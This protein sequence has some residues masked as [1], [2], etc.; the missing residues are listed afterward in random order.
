MLA[1]FMPKPF[2]NLTGNGLHMHLSMWDDEDDRALRRHERQSAGLGMS[3][4]GYRSSPACSTTP[5]PWRRSPA[6][7]STPTSGWP[8]PAPDSGAAWSPVV[9]HLRG[10]RPHPHAPGSRAGPGGESVHRRLGQSVSDH[11]RPSSPPAWTASTGRLNPGDPCELDLLDLTRAEAAER[12]LRSMPMTLWHALE[13]LEADPV[14]RDR[15]RQDTRRRLRR[16]LRRHQ[17]GRG[18]VL[19]CRGH[20][21]GARALPERHLTAMLVPASLAATRAPLSRQRHP[22]T[23]T[24]ARR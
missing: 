10:E 5:R 18:P 23:P 7:R 20:P 1:T 15:P 3:A 6:R 14:L 11:Q 19:P 8:A 4:L 12:G 22:A 2:T 13:H 24:V 21:L 16:L 9:R 17:A